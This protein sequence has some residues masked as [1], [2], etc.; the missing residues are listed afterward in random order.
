M[1]I[2]LKV[3]VNSNVKILVIN[4]TKNIDKHFKLYDTEYDIDL[5]FET[6]INTR[7]DI[8]LNF[9]S[10]NAFINVCLDDEFSL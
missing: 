6:R 7:L 10:T 8:A 3:F 5:G 2:K 4:N 1:I 9:I